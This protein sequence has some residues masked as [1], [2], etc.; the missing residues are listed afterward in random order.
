VEVEKKKKRAE[1][2][3]IVGDEEVLKKRAERFK[4]EIDVIIPEEKAKKQTRRRKLR[5]RTNKGRIGNNNNR[6]LRGSRR[7]SFK[8]RERRNVMARR[9]R[10]Y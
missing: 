3:N 2:F 6:G 7:I 1:R 9:G 5:N 8:G 10:R 4:N